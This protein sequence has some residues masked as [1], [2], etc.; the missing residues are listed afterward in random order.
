MNPTSI[1]IGF[2]AHWKCVALCLVTFQSIFSPKVWQYLLNSQFFNY[3][4]LNNILLSYFNQDLVPSYSSIRG[5]ENYATTS[6]ASFYAH[7]NLVK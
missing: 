4:S 7:F 1:Q 6:Q 2:L 3:S 5:M